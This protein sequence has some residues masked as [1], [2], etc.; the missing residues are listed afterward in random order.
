VRA[1]LIQD[2][3]LFLFS[4]FLFV[5]LCLLVIGLEITSIFLKVENC[6]CILIY[7]GKELVLGQKVKKKKQ[8]YTHQVR[9]KNYK[10]GTIF[11]KRFA[12]AMHEIT[13]I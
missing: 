7:K 12:P 8:L 13:S 10:H 1:V 9:E 4:F 11:A 5:C 2:F 6:L 3:F